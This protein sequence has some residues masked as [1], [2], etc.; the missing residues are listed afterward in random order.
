[1]PYHIGLKRALKALVKYCKEEQ[2]ELNYQKIKI[3]A[4]AK[5]YQIHFWK[6]DSHK[7]KQISC[8][9]HLGVVLYS[10]TNSNPHG[11]YIAENAQKNSSAI[12]KTRD[13]H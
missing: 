8:I 2:L 6:I 9:K 1:M 7:T 4:F 13:G 11:D 12:L 5:R 10:S 3:I